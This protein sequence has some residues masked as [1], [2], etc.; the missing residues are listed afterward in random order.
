MRISSGRV[1]LLVGL[2]LVPSAVM[3]VAYATKALA[4]GSDGPTKE[5]ALAAEKELAQAMRTNDADGVCR[6]LDPDWTVSTVL[7]DLTT[8]IAFAPR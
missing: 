5:S 2:L 3:S 7:A 1:L 8:E 4:E 6:L